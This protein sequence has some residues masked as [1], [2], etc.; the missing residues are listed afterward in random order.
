MQVGG[1]TDLAGTTAVGGAADEGQRVRLADC[2]DGLGLG[3]LEGVIAKL[4]WEVT[5]IC[6]Q[7]RVVETV[8]AIRDGDAHDHVGVDH[9]SAHQGSDEVGGDKHLG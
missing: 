6:C 5:A 3:S 7:R 8:L 9:G 4:A 1:Q 2:D